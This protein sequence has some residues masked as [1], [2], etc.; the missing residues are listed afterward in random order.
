MP[1]S[2]APISLLFN[3]PYNVIY[4]LY[5]FLDFFTGFNR[6]T[7]FPVLLL[8]FHVLNFC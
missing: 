4:S 8:Q 2:S 7:L 6:L 3:F 1:Y 5:K